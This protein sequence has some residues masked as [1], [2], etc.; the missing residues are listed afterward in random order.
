MW[1]D[2]I[3]QPFQGEKIKTNST[4]ATCFFWGKHENYLKLVYEV[5]EDRLDM[6]GSFP[7]KF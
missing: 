1:I 3:H 2:V 6:I 7:T 4:Q 5:E